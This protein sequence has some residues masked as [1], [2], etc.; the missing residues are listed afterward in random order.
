M[1]GAAMRRDERTEEGDGFPAVQETVIV[2]ECDDHHRADDD[3][4]VDNY[5]ALFDGVHA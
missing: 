3:L 5:R 4:A 2:C 1:N